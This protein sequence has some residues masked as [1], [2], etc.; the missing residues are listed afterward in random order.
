MYWWEFIAAGVHRNISRNNELKLRFVFGRIPIPLA[1]CI[2]TPDMS[3]RR[4][5][6]HIIQC[7]CICPPTCSVSVFVWMC[8]AGR[9]EKAIRD[10]NPVTG[11]IRRHCNS[12]WSPVESQAR[13]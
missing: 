7:G 3:F 12:S 4:L 8:I 6:S 5:T 11:Q 9:Q 13:R 2:R 10:S 1:V